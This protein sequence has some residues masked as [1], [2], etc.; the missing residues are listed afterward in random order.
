MLLN[1]GG[2][3]P[4]FAARATRA[5]DKESKYK[6]KMDILVDV[7]DRLGK[8]RELAGKSRDECLLYFLDMTMLHVCESIRSASRQGAVQHS[9][10]V[11]GH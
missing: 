8:I 4:R 2:P 1:F 3:E 11:E 7:A 5:S 10:E 6:S 9:Q